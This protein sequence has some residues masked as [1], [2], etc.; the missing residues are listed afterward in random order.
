MHWRWSVDKEII[1]TF[2]WKVDPQYCDV[3][4]I[5]EKLQEM[6]QCTITDVS[7]KEKKKNA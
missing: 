1:F 6:G 5:V 3:S 2:E 7:V 4:E